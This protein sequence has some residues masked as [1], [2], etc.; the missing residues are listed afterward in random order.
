MKE[1][2]SSDEFFGT[3]QQDKTM[4]LPSADEFFAPPAPSGLGL[5]GKAAKSIITGNGISNP[6]VDEFMQ[7][8]PAGRIMG[9]FGSGFTAGGEGGALGIEPGGEIEQ[10]FTKAGIFNDYA[11]GQH[12]ILKGAN[13]AFIRPAAVV[14]DNE[15]RGVQAAMGAVGGA[16]QQTSEELFKNAPSILGE[17]P[18]FTEYAMTT[19]AFMGA[20]EIPHEISA[21]R[22]VGAIGESEAS[23]FGLREP[24]P[25]QSI[26]RQQAADNIPVEPLVKDIH[27]IAREVAPEIFAKYDV[28][29]SQKEGLQEQIQKAYGEQE[30]IIL[31]K[32]TDDIT[33]IQ[34]KLENK[35]NKGLYSNM[36]EKKI[37]ERDAEISALEDTPEMT[38]LRKQLQTIDYSRRDMAE[39]V[40][41]AYREAQTRVP[42]EE[43]PI[44]MTQEIPQEVSQ[45]INIKPIEQQLHTISNDI[46]QKLI[47][48]GRSEE[49]ANTSAQLIAEHYKAIAEQGW[50][51]GTAEEIYQRDSANIVA[52]K[53]NVKKGIK[54]F[55]QKAK[56]KIRLA[57][58]DAKAAITLF[59]TADASTFIHETGHAWLDEMMRY[60]RAEDAP[61]GLLKDRDTINKWLGIKEGDAITRAQHEKFARGFER[62]LMEGIAPS[63]T[64]ANVF[65]KF[66]KW[67]TDI[68]QTVQKL[69][70]PITDDIRH[71]FDRLLS[72]NPEKTIIVPERDLPE[73]L[74]ESHNKNVN[75]DIIKSSTEATKPATAE[76]MPIEQSPSKGMET[77][78][79]NEELPSE[80]LSIQTQEIGK[81]E[82]TT[83]EKR[84]IANNPNAKLKKPESKFVDKAGNI[85]LDNLNS[86]ED[87]NE[88]IRQTANENDNFIGARRGK[89]S[90]GQVLDLADA[91]GMKPEELNK[92][93]LGQAFNAEQVVASRKL[94]I[95]SAENLR[96]LGAKAAEGKE[97]D[98]AAYVE[99]RSRHIMIQSHVSGI[100]A[101]AGRALRAFKQLEGGAEA[102]AIGDFLKQNTGLDLFQLQQEAKQLLELDSAQKVSKLIQDA[103]K[104]TYKDMILEYY[105]NALISGPITH[106][107][108]S[109]G[110]AIN[111][112]WTPLVEIPTAAGIGKFREVITGK[113]NPERVY[114]GEAGA[115]LHG[116]I[117]GSKNGLQ[118]AATAWKTSVSP[119][120]PTEELAPIFANKVNA[121]PGVLG[122]AINIPSKGVAAIHSFFRSI[123]YEQNIQGLS[124]RMAMKEGLKEGT[125]EFTNRIADLGSNPTEQMMESATAD[126]LKELYMTPTEYNST[127]GYLT[128]FVNSNLAAKIIMPFMKIGSQITRNAFIERTPLGLLTED[129]RGKAFYVEGVPAGDMQLAKMATG[130]ALMGG[131]SALT[132]EGL[133]TGDGPTDP[134]K[135]AIWLM[136]HSPNSLQI[137]DITVKYQGLG[138]LG[139]LMRFAS[140]MTEVAGGLNEDENGSMASGFMESITRSV[141][142]ENF[143]RGLKDM[144]DAVYHHQE[145]GER[146][147]R[148]FA[149]NW[150]PFSVGLGQVSRIIDPSQRE[151]HTI[152][153]SAWNRIPIASEDLFPRRD[154]FG[155][156]IPNGAS[157]RYV[158]DPVVQRME[159]LQMGVGKL[160]KKIRGVTLTEQQY[161]DYARLAGR[162]TKMR[163][164]NYVEIPQTA[165]LPSEIQIKTIHSIITASRETARNIVMMNNID[166]VKQAY[167][168]KVNV[169]KKP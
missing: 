5:A 44:K 131:M 22:S 142:D 62:Y 163:L 36:L 14:L 122:K 15:F 102:S 3:T 70:S 151:F 138:H 115:Q 59:K 158:N 26:A 145:Y 135:R 35:N 150:V 31:A 117:Q 53:E 97:I 134:N 9:A 7:K 123:R 167:Q 77:P 86:L 136:N 153:E 34:N 47:S 45:E 137:G 78:S 148:Q 71:V 108:Y 100:T 132:L 54:E 72:S 68:Y 106:L 140:N 159:S 37:A 113:V 67:L 57:T 166:I 28:L 80:I 23:Y 120:L 83:E 89:I 40:S 116:I 74:Q 73:T 107:R 46:S 4:S 157:E 48:A 165:K 143:M 156:E 160:D 169:L 147:I 87:I 6:A 162:I 33:E 104:P 13:E 118:A 21:A 42:P 49:E 95:Q 125:E 103:K 119:A 12:D 61:A 11:K 92:R 39:D 79:K 24:T 60:A 126:A 133:A 29:T 58:D 27:T 82:L 56:G 32:Y 155:E 98:L 152:L 76:G 65:T 17:I 168:N 38:E 88:I 101:E 96:D 114:L 51:K 121:I 75:E 63:Q 69:K 146:Y 111:A 84:N 90:D 127:A 110:N 64:L 161:D 164:N 105:I 124:Y 52:G 154:K 1:L 112:L 94:L 85:R 128:R 25:E 149:T 99:A 20:H 141:L 81:S 139:M 30:S 2:P 50:A 10:A 55:N 43:I 91:L 8:T 18:A 19:P 130:V 16:I 144:L 109:V 41:A 93:K 129:V 66:K